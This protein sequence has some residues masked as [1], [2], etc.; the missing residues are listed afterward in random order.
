MS[1]IF[2][3][4]LR[5]LRA[6]LILLI[7][8]YS[9]ATLGMTLIPGI[10]PNGEP[11][12][13]SFFHAF[14]FVSFMGTTIG[15]GEIPYAFT[16]TQRA[17]VLVCIY[18]SVVAWL[19]AIGNMLKL[20]QDETFQSAVAHRNFERGIKRID[21]P[22][23][24][25]CG[26]GETGEFINRGLT[27]LNMQTV[28]IDQDLER[29][30]SLELDNLTIPPIVLNADITEPQNLVTAGI[31]HPNCQGVIAVTQTDH[32][33]LQI[34]V[35]AKLINNKVPVIC[36]SEIEDEAANMASF[37]TDSII[38]PYTTFA[39]RMCLLAQNPGL[40][41]IQNWFINQHSA[42]H[43]SE[44]IAEHGLPHGKW[45]VCG[46]GR[47]G[48]AIQQFLEFE[49][50]DIVVVDPDPD[51]HGAPEDT[52][53][54][55]GTE[56]A[57][58]QEAGIEEASIV[59]AAS[60]DDANNLSVLITARQ[61]NPNIITVGR[62]SREAS[63]PLFENAQCDYIMR[64]GQVVANEALTIISRPLVTRFIKNS[65]KLSTTETEQL[66]QDICLLTGDH[67]PVTWRLTVDQL[68]APAMVRFLE[69]GRSLS[70]GDISSNDLLPD[71]RCIPLLLQR[72]GVSHLLPSSDM[73]LEIN[74]Q[75]LL[76]AKRGP[77]NLAQRLRDNIELLDTLI[78]DN[79]HHI[80]L[81]RFLARRKTNKTNHKNIT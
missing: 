34:A 17:W 26:F 77:T 48:K 42:E 53:K 64:R 63:H 8:M 79:P 52:I 49:T 23:Y 29:T 10:D 37:G 24:I 32:T 47:L 81:L 73:N 6:P 31:N 54:G 76:C 38:N 28:I 62:V 19:Y 51:A 13:M 68:N 41:R 78:N 72:S 11:W 71:A 43:I 80:P 36:R 58:L 4:V 3:L 45:I 61:L 44:Q 46:Y 14:Y 1:D 30:R 9:V 56:A 59:I 18:T 15:F 21:L 69:S 2:F 16:D 25:I 12:R 35:A 67:A 55:R 60:D 66:I 40:Y 50:I 57:T 5:R 70:I 33:N 65:A 7:L 27:D 20:L 75:L 74:D 22:F 39:R